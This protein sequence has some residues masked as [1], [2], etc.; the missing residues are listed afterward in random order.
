MRG[1]GFQGE[2]TVKN[3]GTAATSGWKVSWTFGGGQT[4]SQFWGAKVTQNGA[5]VTAANESWNGTLAAGA[6]TTFG[7]IGT[8]TGE[9]VT[10]ACDGE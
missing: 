7:F 3:T 2:V 5:A 6:S 4:I 8:G 9:T 10:P 1:G